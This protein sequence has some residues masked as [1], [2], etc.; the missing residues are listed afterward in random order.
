MEIAKKIS[1]PVFVE[2]SGLFIKALNRFPG[3]YSSYVY[4]TL[5]LSG[6]LKLLSSVQDRE[7]EFKSVI[8]FCDQKH[9]LKCFLGSVQG[10][11]SYE[12]RGVSGFGFDPLFEPNCGGGK[13]FAEMSVEEKC[14]I[15][16]RGIVLRKFA[17]WYKKYIRNHTL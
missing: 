1:Y 8:A 5:G 17:K 16:H 10:T 13:T 2:D 9:T 3:P 7:A 6:I 11:I 4:Q 15:S 12:A 14:L